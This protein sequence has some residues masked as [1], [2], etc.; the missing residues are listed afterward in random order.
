MGGKEVSLSCC[1]SPV[2]P[3]VG[4]GTPSEPEPGMCGVVHSDSQKHTVMPSS[5]LGWGVSVEAVSLSPAEGL[6]TGWYVAA[7]S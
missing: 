3:R 2:V 1:L 6:Q 5:C 7:C 4:Q